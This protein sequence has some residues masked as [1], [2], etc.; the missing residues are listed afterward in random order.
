M[1][2][3]PLS[4]LPVF[5]QGY[6]VD[7]ALLYAYDAGTTTPRSL[8]LTAA[9]DL[10]HA[11]QT[12]VQMVDGVFPVMFAGPGDYDLWIY[13]S[14]GALIRVISGLQ[15]DPEVGTVG[16][17]FD[18]LAQVA[19]G[20][21]VVAHRTGRRAGY[22]RANAD[23]LTIGSSASTA[24]ERAN[25]DCHALF[26]YLYTFDPSLAV[27]GGRSSAGAEADWN[28]NKTIALPNESGRFNIAAGVVATVYMK[29]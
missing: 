22:V 17:A 24:T 15:G 11:H 14:D 6:P 20:D 4:G 27:T 3:C 16:A 19:T 10:D 1:A 12:P 25:D 28:G 23:G 13:G 2:Y 5:D 29:L 26:V 7:G 8:Y 18:P 9:I 21:V